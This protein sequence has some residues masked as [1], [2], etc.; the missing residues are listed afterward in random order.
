MKSAIVIFF[1]SSF[2]ILGYLTQYL[3]NS[4]LKPS[5]PSSMINVRPL[6][7][8]TFSPLCLL[9]LS[10]LRQLTFSTYGL[11]APTELV[12]D[13]IIWDKRVRLAN[14]TLA[15]L[16]LSYQSIGPPSLDILQRA[17]TQPQQRLT[18]LV[19]VANKL[20][21]NG[22]TQLARFLPSTLT[23]LALPSNQIGDSGAAALGAKLSPSLTVLYL[24]NNAIG[25]SGAAAIAARLPPSL[26]VLGLSSNMIGTTGAFAIAAGLPP[27]LTELNLNNNAIGDAGAAAIRQMW[28]ARGGFLKL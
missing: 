27:S 3:I 1:F 28:A 2:V 25:D 11:T 7:L 20:G 16:D 26:T 4:Q 15:K 9:L 22:A 8:L 23:Y 14:G 17:L 21:P 6:C 18:Q 12:G 19:L 24:G 5:W 10:R 13:R